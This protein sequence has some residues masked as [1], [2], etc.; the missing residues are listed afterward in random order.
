MDLKEGSKTISVFSKATQAYYTRLVIAENGTTRQNKEL[1]GISKNKHSG[2][3]CYMK[4]EQ[5]AW[6]IN[7]I[8]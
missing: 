5:K 7:F 2:T 1:I 8:S 3:K 4:I 6:Q